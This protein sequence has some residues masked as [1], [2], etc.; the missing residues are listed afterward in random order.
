MN[1]ILDPIVLEPAGFTPEQGWAE[2]EQYVKQ[3]GGVT[4][5]DG[6]VNWRAAFGADPGCCS[7]PACHVTYW[8]WGARVRCVRCAF[9]FPTDWWPMYSYG[10]SAATAKMRGAK[11]HIEN[12]NGLRVLHE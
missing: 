8:A 12:H 7:C 1:E 10:V 3:C 6:E 2:C 4:N 11:I 5:K 9:E